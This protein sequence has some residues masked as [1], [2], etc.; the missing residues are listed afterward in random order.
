MLRHGILVGEELGVPVN[1]ALGLLGRR[2][3]Q[4][5]NRRMLGNFSTPLGGQ[6]EGLQ[7]GLRLAWMERLRLILECRGLRGPIC[8]SHQQYLILEGRLGQGMGP[9]GSVPGG[10]GLEHDQTALL[11]MGLG[12][13]CRD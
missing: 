12:V 4:W 9:Q 3:S 2:Q 7:A 10:S 11:Q 1:V 13:G 8:R 5:L 6:G